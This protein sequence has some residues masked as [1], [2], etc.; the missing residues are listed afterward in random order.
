MAIRRD[1]TTE[2][3]DRALVEVALCNGNTRAAH[4][5]LK[6]EGVHIPRPNIERWA[7]VL[8]RQRYQELRAELV[9][10]IHAKIAAN[11]EDRAE[12]ADE[13]ER[14]MLAKFGEDF[15]QLAPRDQAGAIRNVSTVKAIN[16]DKAALLRGQP[17]EI[18]KHERS[19]DELWAEFRQMFPS[20]IPGTAVE[21]TDADL[22]PGADSGAD[23]AL[24]AG[25]ERSVETVPRDTENPL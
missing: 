23:L 9:P 12:Q 6:A 25:S 4:R 16:V 21:I 2:E 19:T 17:T 7:R 3:I 5:N 13:L 10:R 22:V 18:V 15:E 1:Y 8:Y 14:K 20:I 11:C 24:E